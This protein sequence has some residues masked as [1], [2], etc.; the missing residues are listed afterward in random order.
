[1]DE[2]LA[3]G[4]AA[5]QKKCLGKMGEVA[6]KGRTIIFVSHNM[7]AINNICK[8]GILINK[9]NIEEKGDIKKITSTYLQKSQGYGAV[10]I[11]NNLSNWPIRF[12]KGNARIINAK[13]LN[14]KKDSTTIVYRTKPMIV[15]FE[16]DNYKKSKLLLT[17]LILSDKDER[18]L[19]LSQCDDPAFQLSE[20]IGRYII[21]INIPSAPLCSGKYKMS[22]G[23]HSNYL[24][25]EDIVS[26][27]LPFSVYDAPDSPRPFLTT[28]KYAHC[29]IQS[30]WKVVQTDCNRMKI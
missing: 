11:N 16:I 24:E 26:E 5:F 20:Q 30:Q 14:E 8:K 2:V 10:A 13:I 15:E 19:H 28:N 6:Q 3:V 21:Q 12:G 29:W 1:V 17:C 18:I 4:D 22:I 9:G 7:V 27:I 23:I 25:P